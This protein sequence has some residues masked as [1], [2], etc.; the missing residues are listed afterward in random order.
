MILRNFLI[1]ISPSFNVNVRHFFAHVN[2]N[3]RK[4]ANYSHL[5]YLKLK[6]IW[7]KLGCGKPKN[8]RKAKTKTKSNERKEK[9]KKEKDKFDYF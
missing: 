9:V 5:N 1:F 4:N 3:G 8:K 7:Q 2:V 6:N